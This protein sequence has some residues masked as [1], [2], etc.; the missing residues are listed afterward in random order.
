VRACDEER[1]LQTNA[2][3][4]DKPQGTVVTYLRCGG[5]FNNQI[6]RF[7]LLSLLGKLLK[8]VNIWHSYGQNVDCVVHFLRLLAVWWPGTESARDNHLFACNFAKYLPV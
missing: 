8:S 6:K 2:V 3:I 4:N 5:I 1:Q 7:L